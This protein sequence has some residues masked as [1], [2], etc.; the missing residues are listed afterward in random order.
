MP[1]V[2]VNLNDLADFARSHSDV[3]VNGDEYISA[4]TLLDY[5]GYTPIQEQQY[6][7]WNSIGGG[8]PYCTACGGRAIEGKDGKPVKTKCCPHCGTDM[9]E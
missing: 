9:G 2:L 8:W 3:E 1:E 7:R 5:D 6:G 4:E